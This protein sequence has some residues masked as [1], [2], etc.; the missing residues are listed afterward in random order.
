MPFF[1]ISGLERLA[2]WLV[3]H[4]TVTGDPL[5]RLRT[6]DGQAGGSAVVA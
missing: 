6:G 5:T 1:A 3:E 2:G 4:E